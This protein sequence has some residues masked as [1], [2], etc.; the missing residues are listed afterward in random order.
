MFDF[1]KRKKCEHDYEFV[2]NIYGDEINWCEGYRSE[3]RCKKCGKIEYRKYLQTTTILDK[4]D[5]LYDEYYKNKYDEWC[6]L[7][8]ETLNHMLEVMIDNAKNGLCYA[9][10]VLFCEE[11]HNDKNYYEKWF[12]ENKLKHESKLLGNEK[13]DECNKYEFHI[14]WQYK[15]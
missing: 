14:R 3:W 11:K 4:L 6:S 2:R 7:R 15:Y 1:V 13:C 8:S 12:D 9:D 5:K 10:F